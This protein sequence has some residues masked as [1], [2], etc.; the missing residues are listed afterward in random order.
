[1]E[2]QIIRWS[3]LLGVVCVLV[4]V[5]FRA[6]NAAGWLH[7]IDTRGAAIGYGSFLKGAVLFLL[8]CVAT[9]SYTAA[10]RS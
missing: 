4:A 6:M 3:Y 9:S 10:Q 5:L 1:M 7:D 2:K 8:T